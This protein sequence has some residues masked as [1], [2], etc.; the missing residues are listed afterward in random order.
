MAYDVI[1]NIAAE[2]AKKRSESGVPV[3][4]D[5]TVCVI[6]TNTGNIYTGLNGIEMRNGMA[7]PVHAE[8]DAINNMRAH[9]ENIIEAVTVLNSFNLTPI[10]PCNNCISIIIS[11][12]PENTKCQ[13]VTPNRNIG[14]IEVNM[15]IANAGH[16]NQGQPNNNMNRGYMQNNLYGYQSDSHNNTAVHSPN[17]PPQSGGYKPDY[18]QYNNQMQSQR[19]ANPGQMYSNAQINQNQQFVNPV[20]SGQV[21]SNQLYS[22]PVNSSQINSQQLNSFSGIS[23]RHTS[24]LYSPDTTKSSKGDYL[25]NKV[26]NLLNDDVED[27]DEDEDNSGKKKNKKKFGGLFGR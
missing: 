16:P 19:P 14:I 13:I 6:R 26:N 4:P 25:K 3:N 18:Q 21:N 20:T 23:S 11:L 17:V 1:L 12:N 24:S 7:I 9:D 5:D 27:E 10:L 22:S 15:Y 2:V 8:I